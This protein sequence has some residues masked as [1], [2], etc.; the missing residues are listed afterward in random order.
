M[1]SASRSDQRQNRL[2]DL[3]ERI[4][5][6]R[7]IEYPSIADMQELESARAEAG[8]INALLD[9]EECNGT[10]KLNDYDS[11]TVECDSCDGTGKRGGAA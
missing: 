10:G 6:L 5:E 8:K 9:C 7:R 1:S 2:H 4:Y 11:S 3:E